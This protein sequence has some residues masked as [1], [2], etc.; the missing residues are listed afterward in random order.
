MRVRKAVKKWRGSGQSGRRVLKIKWMVLQYE[1]MMD[2]FSEKTRQL[3]QKCER[4]ESVGE[5]LK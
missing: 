2:E 4:V 1:G 3:W 5:K